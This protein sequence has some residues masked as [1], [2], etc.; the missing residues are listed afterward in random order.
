[1]SLHKLLWVFLAREKG[2]FFETIFEL[3]VGVINTP[4]IG[5]VC[6]TSNQRETT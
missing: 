1:M 2:G 5:N 6:G 4:R 3:I